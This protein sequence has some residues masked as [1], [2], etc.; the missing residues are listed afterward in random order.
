MT[1]AAKNEDTEANDIPDTTA[2]K[3]PET[4]TATKSKG[5]SEEVMIRKDHIREMTPTSRQKFK[6][7]KR[8]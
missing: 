8:N 4:K 1:S 7:C 2:E 5:E 3:D 6:T